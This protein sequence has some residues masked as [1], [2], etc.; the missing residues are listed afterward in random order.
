MIQ[1]HAVGNARA[2]IVTG[3]AKALMAERVHQQDLIQRHAALGIGVV[4]LSAFGFAAVAIASKVGSDHGKMVR[5]RRCDFAPCHMGLRMTVEQQQ[6][7][8]L[9][10]HRCADRNAGSK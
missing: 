6:G 9:S 7:R 3:H 4:V 10:A 8:S 5:Q 1:R 2:A